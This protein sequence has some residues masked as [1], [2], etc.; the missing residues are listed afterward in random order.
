MKI[1]QLQMAQAGFFDRFAFGSGRTNFTIVANLL[2]VMKE[3]HDQPSTDLTQFRDRFHDLTGKFKDIEENEISRQDFLENS[4]FVMRLI[5][6]LANF[7]FGFTFTAAPTI[8]EFNEQLEHLAR[9]ESKWGLKAGSTMIDGKTYD[10]HAMPYLNIMSWVNGGE[11]I[12]EIYA[13]NTRFIVLNEEKKR[14]GEMNIRREYEHTNGDYDH[15]GRAKGK[16][17]TER[18]L[19]IEW[20]EDYKQGEKTRAVMR[21][22][23]QVA[24]EIFQRDKDL[25][26]D[27]RT[28]HD[29]SY[30]QVQAGFDAVSRD[31]DKAEDIKI[32]LGNSGIEKTEYPPYKDEGVYDFQMFKRDNPNSGNTAFY[33][34]AQDGTETDVKILGA[35][36]SEWAGQDKTTWESVISASP[37]LDGE[38]PVFPEYWNHDPMN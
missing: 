26:L 22:L 37:I 12:A 36:R 8:K 28:T 32:M 30:V 1:D 4:H 34:K 23:T 14:I 15:E 18:Y 3:Y 5:C 10:V 21:V 20:M 6:R 24:M 17:I 35:W 7:I 13:D 11:D 33:T 9:G 25:R 38:G 29:T 27:L 31:H 16:D 19:N 2:N